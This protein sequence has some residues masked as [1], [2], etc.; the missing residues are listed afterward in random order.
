[1]NVRMITAGGAF[2]AADDWIAERVGED[3]IAVTA[4]IPLAARCLDKG[5]W[6]L[7]PRGE[8]FTEETIGDALASRALMDQLRQMGL[9]SGG[10]PPMGKQDRSRYLSRL[11]EVIQAIK[12]SRG[13]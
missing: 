8:D 13:P 12:R 2:D 5:A 7:S 3:D 11:D 4:D 6:V 1:P 9:A 10:P